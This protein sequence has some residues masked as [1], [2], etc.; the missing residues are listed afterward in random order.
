MKKLLAVSALGLMMAAPAFAQPYPPVPPPRAE[1]VPPP[2]GAQY[3]WEGGH[4]HWNGAQYAWVPGHYVVRR[5][6]WHNWVP[7]HWA[8]RGGR[9]VWVPAHW[10]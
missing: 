4:W 9:W 8:D 7:G 1:M 3:A 2:P 6:G 5:A 10:Q